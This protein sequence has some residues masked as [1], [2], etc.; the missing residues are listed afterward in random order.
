[1]KARIPK[2]NNQEM[3]QA[4]QDRNNFTIELGKPIIQIDEKI[5][6]IYEDLVQQYG[7]MRRLDIIEYM[8]KPE[9]V[10]LF[11]PYTSPVRKRINE[12]VLKLG[13]EVII[14]ELEDSVNQIQKNCNI[15]ME[16][17]IKKMHD[18][19]F[20]L[21]LR[22][23]VP[24]SLANIAEKATNKYIS[25]KEQELRKKRE[26]EQVTSLDSQDKSLQETSKKDDTQSNQSKKQ[27]KDK[28]TDGN[29]KAK[30]STQMSTEEKQ[31]FEQVRNFT[32][33]F[34]FLAKDILIHT[35]ETGRRN[36]VKFNKLDDY[37]RFTKIQE[38]VRQAMIL[39][40]TDESSAIKS[41]LNKS[42][43]RLNNV[44]FN[45]LNARKQQLDRNRNLIGLP[46]K[47]EM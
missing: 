28:K 32:N 19:Q 18:K 8:R 45:I 42:N 29:R 31:F 16:T 33:G 41:I 12:S 1:M 15:T 13:E 7:E 38:K 46:D 14:K 26:E 44:D 21:R 30:E 20:P 34:D 22:R 25:E 40:K 6:R 24:H 47:Q 36:P 23:S 37:I 43:G 10:N 2:Q 27:K 3:I 11:S 9:F 39:L 5:Q 4:S 17:I 35:S